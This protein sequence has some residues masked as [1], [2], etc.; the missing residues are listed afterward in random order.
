[1]KDEGDN[2]RVHLAARQHGLIQRFPDEHQEA[3]KDE[4]K[5]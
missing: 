4:K 1:M 2:G 3:K 5:Q